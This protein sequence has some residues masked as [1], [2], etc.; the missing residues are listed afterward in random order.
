MKHSF[1]LILLVLFAQQVF[2]VA[3][4]C[5]RIFLPQ[6]KNQKSC[7]FP[8][9]RKNGRNCFAAQV[10]D[11][12]RHA[13]GYKD[14][15]LDKV[16]EAVEMTKQ[17]S[18]KGVDLTLLMS[19]LA[20]ESWYNPTTTN[21][22]G[23]IG[24]SQ[25]Q[26]ATAQATVDYM[27]ELN[28][29]VPEEVTTKLPPKCKKT[30]YST[31]LSA[32]CFQSIQ[33]VCETPEYSN[34]LF[35]PH[36]ALKLMAFHFLQIKERSVIVEYEGASH[37]LSLILNPPGDEEA[38]IRYTASIYNRGFRIYNSAFH[39]FA[40]NSKWLT[41]KDYG[42]LWNVERKISRD[43]DPFAGGTLYKHYI[44]RCYVWAIGGLCGGLKESVIESYSKLLCP[45]RQPILSFASVSQFQEEYEKE[46]VPKTWSDLVEISKASH[47][48]DLS[49]HLDL[50]F[51]LY[52]TQLEITNKDLLEL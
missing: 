20:K 49:K 19:I 18:L 25:F 4:V 44:N 9:K 16:Q 31:P 37:N 43:N 17:Y 3:P 27:R 7:P 30:K 52:E 41:A 21:Q 8:P 39:Y 22:W 24:I 40:K 46:K 32:A 14:Y 11:L 45:N 1:L 47:S 34:S 13:E 12:D 33:E 23:D 48:T 50:A 51:S 29:P 38:D 6:I 10:I 35:C 5:D 28:I 36:F 42:P 2:S 26:P 15:I